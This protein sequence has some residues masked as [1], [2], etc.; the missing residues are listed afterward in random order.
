VGFPFVL[1]QANSTYGQQLRQFVLM[2]NYTAGYHPSTN[3]TNGG[4]T[5]STNDDDTFQLTNVVL[6]LGTIL[7][8]LIILFLIYI[9]SDSVPKKLRCRSSEVTRR[10][11][12]V[13]GDFKRPLIYN[14]NDDDE[15]VGC[16]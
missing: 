14:D 15:N 3:I 4:I 5:S 11:G 12:V 8:V 13:E 10:G 9:W 1:Y 6:I 7:P 2:K 16:R